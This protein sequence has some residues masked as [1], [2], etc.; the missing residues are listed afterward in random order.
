MLGTGWVVCGRR[1]AAA[2]RVALARHAGLARLLRRSL[3]VWRDEG[4]AGIALRWK[5]LLSAQRPAP[6]SPQSEDSGILPSASSGSGPSPVPDT[7]WRQ[8]ER[9]DL[10]LGAVLV[11]HPY[12]VLGRGEDVRTGTCAFAAADIPFSL[13]NTFGDY[14]KEQAAFQQNFPFMDRIDPRTARKANVFYLNANEMDDA[15]AHLGAEFFGGCY[16]IGYWAWEL[17]Q[18]PDAWLSAFRYVDEIWVH[19]RFIQQS[20]AHKAPC[21]VLCMPVAVEP[22]SSAKFSRAY[23]DLPERG[24]LILFFFDFRSFI[25]R[26]NPEAA[27]KAFSLAFQNHP[28]ARVHLIIKVNGADAR[29][30]DYQ[31]FLNSEAVRD[32]RVILLDKVMQDWEITELV[33]LCDCFLSLHRSEGF[34]RGLAEA[35][36]FGKPVVATGYSGNVDFMNEANSCLVDYTLVAVGAD[37][38]PHGAGQ[39]WADPDVEQAAWFLRKLTEDAAQAT[40]IGQR[41]AHYIRTY[42]SFA[43]V[44]ARHRRRLEKL[45]LLN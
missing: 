37:E 27:L 24:F 26:K 16:N 29:P 5:L 1:L 31:A 41:A 32:P 34:G 7:R 12:A 14:G 36:Y 8:R 35:M 44:G 18:F 2:L 3:A 23:F 6:L 28:D 13:R 25:H 33:R 20:I 43:A 4:L 11:G 19:S 42:H 15:F 30:D 21:P 39:S 40:E 38:Y 45:G 22:F 17:S 9:T 10:L